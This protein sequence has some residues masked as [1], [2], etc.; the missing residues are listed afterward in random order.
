[1]RIRALVFCLLL[2]YVV[3]LGEVM[4]SYA[5]TTRE[6]GSVAKFREAIRG[7]EDIPPDFCGNPAGYSKD[8]DDLESAVFKAAERVILEALNEDVPDSGGAGGRV[9]AVLKQLEEISASADAHWPKYDRFSAGA[10]NLGDAMVVEVSFRSRARVFAFGIRSGLQPSQPKKQWQELYLDSSRHLNNA[11]SWISIYS[12]HSNSP[13]HPR[14]LI[15]YGYGG[16]AGST[17]VTYAGYEWDPRNISSPDD[18]IKQRGAFGLDDKVKGFPQI[19]KLQ[20]KGP[21]VALPFCWF[22]AIDTWDNPSLCAVDKYDLSGE[23][24]H[25]ISRTYNRPDLLPIAR[26]IQFA[27][28]HDYRAVRAY[29]GSSAVARNLVRE[30]PPFV[31]AGEL[32][33]KR[34]GKNKEKVGFEDSYR[35]TVERVGGRW[36]V[37]SFAPN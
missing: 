20:T 10:L 29:C 24:V 27:Q 31:F 14:F 12:L 19:G 9:T 3:C 25:F 4:P 30:I 8:Q 23:T 15:R 13:D 11:Q 36:L 22:S 32:E 18:I 37:T 34:V 1:M 6:S 35:F 16:C 26:V 2:P 7:S 28:K 33:V 21:V 17:G 5:A